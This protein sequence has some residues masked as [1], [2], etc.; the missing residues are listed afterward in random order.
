MRPFSLLTAE[1]EADLERAFDWYEG[2]Q[3]GLGSELVAKV[4]EYLDRIVSNPQQYQE[5]HHGVRR[6][7]LSRFPYSVFYLLD[8]GEVV[9][10]AIE[11]QARD[12][13]H[14]KSRL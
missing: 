3:P 10:V 13:E 14:W 12:P 4:E 2:Q 6:A 11:P 1:A 5:V 7:V 8:A 9:V